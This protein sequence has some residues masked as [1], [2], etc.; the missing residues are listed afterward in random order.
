[1]ESCLKRVTEGT[2]FYSSSAI[3]FGPSEIDSFASIANV[4]AHETGGPGWIGSPVLEVR[5]NAIVLIGQQSA[6]S[7]TEVANTTDTSA[8][9]SSTPP[10]QTSSSTSNDPLSTPQDLSRKTVKIVGSIIGIIGL[11]LLGLGLLYFRRYRKKRRHRAEGA[12]VTVEDEKRHRLSDKP[13][14]EGSQ[15]HRG[16]F[17]KAEL[18]ALAIRAE[19][20]GSPGEEQDPAGVGFIKPEL[21]GTPGVWGSLGAFVKRKAELEAPSNADVE[22]QGNSRPFSSAQ[23]QKFVERDPEPVELDSRSLP[24]NSNVDIIREISH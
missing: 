22:K 13:E 15:A 18:D 12:M 16:P 9:G 19:L 14:L 11:V 2:F 10:A 24:H 3:A 4:L 23:E 20:E 17:F 21:H 8:N 1:M 7:R 5:A 6:T